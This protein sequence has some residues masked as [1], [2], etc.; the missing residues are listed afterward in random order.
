M[1]CS[2]LKSPIFS[3]KFFRMFFD[4]FPF[5]FFL[6]LLINAFL[7]LDSSLNIYFALFI[8]IWCRKFVF[9]ALFR[10]HFRYCIIL[11]LLNLSDD[12]IESIWF[13]I[14]AF[15]GIFQL[16]FHEANQLLLL[17]HK[18][19]IIGL[20]SHRL[21]DLILI[22][23]HLDLVNWVLEPVIEQVSIESAS[24]SVQCLF[25]QLRIAEYLLEERGIDKKVW[26]LKLLY[27]QLIR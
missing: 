4:I 19:F 6:F 18:I 3:S 22:V 23:A 7:K 5:S 24:S 20:I 25:W 9:F 16:V 14:H 10:F 27:L 11:I 21:L 26:H 1:K 8:F 2:N 13:S 17:F 15:L 12:V